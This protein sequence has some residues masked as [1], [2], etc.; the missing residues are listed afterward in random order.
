MSFD[1]LRQHETSVG[2]GDSPAESGDGE[3]WAVA[4]A[5]RYFPWRARTRP[6]L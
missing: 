5:D 2:A 6:R 1:P 3:P 4:Q